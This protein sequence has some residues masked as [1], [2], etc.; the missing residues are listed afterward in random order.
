V[1]IERCKALPLPTVYN[2]GL[3]AVSSRKEAV[4]F[5]GS[6]NII[7]SISP[8]KEECRKALLN[9]DY[10]YFLDEAESLQDEGAHLICISVEAEGVDE[11]AALPKAVMAAQTGCSL[12]LIIESA[13][14]KALERAARNYSG[15][16]ML[17]FI[18]GSKVSLE[19]VF[20]LIKKYG[21][22]A[23]CLPLD[24]NGEVTDRIAAAE[25]IFAAAESYGVERR[26]L[27]FDLLLPA[28]KDDDEFSKVLVFFEK[29]QEWDVEAVI[30][31]TS[32]E[33]GRPVR[34]AVDEDYLRQLF[35]EEVSGCYL[36]PAVEI[37]AEIH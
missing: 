36:D 26:N 35:N 21:G 34:G 20:P 6:T 29:L 3:T 17:S 9:E 10:D 31:V 13:N 18:D 24:E 33:K 2:M 19:R 25:K 4:Y 14:A 32:F 30:G 27:L 23:L 28:G 5:G 37:S 12:P 8:D 22:V 7:G 11:E 15:K 16:P 1:M